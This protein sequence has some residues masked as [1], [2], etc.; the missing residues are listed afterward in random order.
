MI[1]AKKATFIKKDGSQRTIVFCEIDDLPFHVIAKK[2]KNSGVSKT[3]KDGNRLVYDLDLKDFRTFNENTVV[4][5]IEKI[6]LDYRF[7]ND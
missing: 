2:F 5:N 6:T 7:D 4:G 3:F 1:Q